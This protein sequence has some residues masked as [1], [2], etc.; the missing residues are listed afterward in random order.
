MGRFNPGAQ[1]EPQFGEEFQLGS[2]RWFGK[3]ALVLEPW[4]GG[5]GPRSP[6]SGPCLAAALAQHLVSIGHEALAHQGGGA[7]GTGEAAVVPVAVFKG[8]V[9]AS[10]ES[11]REAGD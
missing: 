8:H 11:W 1:G 10:T 2:Q 6:G 9:L 7:A 3:G 4:L 5:P